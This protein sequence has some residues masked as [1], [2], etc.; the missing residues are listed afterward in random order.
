MVSVKMG[1]REEDID[2]EIKGARMEMDGPVQES[3]GQPLQFTEPLEW[4]KP[5]TNH[6]LTFSHPEDD[7]E[8]RCGKNR[9]RWLKVRK[10]TLQVNEVIALVGAISFRRY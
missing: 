4:T 2:Q 7:E 8:S 10:E 6:H 5:L 9:F 1:E 3:Q